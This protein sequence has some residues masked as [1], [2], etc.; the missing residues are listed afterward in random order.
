MLTRCIDFDRKENNL[1]ESR[2]TRGLYW[3]HR[4]YSYIDGNKFPMNTTNGT[5]GR[6]RWLRN[7]TKWEYLY[8]LP[9]GKS[10]PHGSAYKF[11]VVAE[12]AREL[13]VDIP[14]VIKGAILD[15]ND[16]AEIIL[17]RKSSTRSDL[18]KKSSL[19][20]LNRNVI[21]LLMPIVEIY[22]AL[23]NDER[24][25]WLGISKLD[26]YRK[27][28]EI[29]LWENTSFIDLKWITLLIVDQI[30]DIQGWTQRLIAESLWG[31]YLPIQS[32][33]RSIQQ[34]AI[35]RQSIIDSWP[36]GQ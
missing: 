2:I 11:K 26:I 30:H 33:A 31:S 29:L 16:E 36:S 18:F 14:A 1:Y 23:E 20:A 3:L 19:A 4:L 10:E 8:H 25:D 22:F 12:I 28:F 34:V 13:V 24:I 7:V 35:H 6:V 32:L 15:Q 17:W 5:A 27:L 21:I 9:S